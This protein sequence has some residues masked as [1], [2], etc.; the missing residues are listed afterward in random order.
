MDT[1]THFVMGAAIGG[2]A[3]LDPVVMSS[4]ATATAVLIAAIVG[5]QAPDV[6][7]ILKLKNNALYIK[8]HRGI[9]H[10]IPA[11]I[12]WPIGI[13]LILLLFFPDANWLHL[14]SWA[15]L[16]VFLHVFVDIFNAYGTQALRPFSDKWVALGWIN[17]FDPFIFGIHLVGI[18]FWTLGAHPGYTFLAIYAVLVVYY[19]LRYRSKQNIKRIISKRFPDLKKVIIAPTIRFYQWRVAIIDH[20]HFYVGKAFKD[21]LI[22]YDEF[23]RLPFPKEH[24]LSA[25]QGD[26]NVSAFLSFS[27][28]YRWEIEEEDDKIEVRFIDLRYRK[29][30]HYP[31]VAIVHLDRDLNIISS[32]TGWV[33]SEEKLQKKLEILPD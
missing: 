11:V 10:S 19:I 29:D 23:K 24:I 6:D 9:T 30:G 22:I 17:T 33:Y 25:I 7:T 31:F 20:D 5:S 28:A 15:F 27:P 18:M 16:A 3:T 2:L 1:G 8:H 12:L 4:D 21:E 14:W 13:T 26:E 32:F